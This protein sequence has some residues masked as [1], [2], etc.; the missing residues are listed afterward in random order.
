MFVPLA[1][2]IFG[3][4]NGPARGPQGPQTSMSSLEHKTNLPK[5]ITRLFF[6]ICHDH[7]CNFFSKVSTF[8]SLVPVLIDVF[9]HFALDRILEFKKSWTLELICV[10]NFLRGVPNRHCLLASVW[11]WNFFFWWFK[12]FLHKNQQTQRKLLILHRHS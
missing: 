11:F 9:T 5:L 2:Q 8:C 7:T 3:P 4:S 6:Q 12:S 1:L 10:F